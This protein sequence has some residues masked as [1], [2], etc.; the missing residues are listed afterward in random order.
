MGNLR[1]RLWLNIALAGMV[2]ALGLWAAFGSHESGEKQ[3][4]LTALK[5]EEVQ[6]ILV[7]RPQFETVELARTE[8]GWNLRRAGDIAANPEQVDTLLALLSA[9]V[10][11]RYPVKSL[12]LA[13]VGLEPPTLVVEADGKRIELGGVN[14]LSFRRYTR[15]DEEVRLIPDQYEGLLTTA[16]VDFA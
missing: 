7:L 15:V 11:S 8:S 16:S 14:E 3:E 10:L 1:A 2:L 6:R 9:P 4:S 13:E 12:Q 5:P